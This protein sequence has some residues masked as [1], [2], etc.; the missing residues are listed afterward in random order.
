MPSEQ[1]SDDYERRMRLYQGIVAGAIADPRERRL[2]GH[3]G[4]ATPQPASLHARQA[5]AVHPA[6]VSISHG[7]RVLSV[8]RRRD[9][10]TPQ[11]IERVRAAL[12]ARQQTRRPIQM[13]GGGLSW[14]Y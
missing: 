6:L 9:S 4:I 13:D 1:Q 7:G 12:Q 8:G 5:P 11:A 10:A 2:R 14:R 3:F